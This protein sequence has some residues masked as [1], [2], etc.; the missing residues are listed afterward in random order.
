MDKS[1]ENKNTNKDEYYFG[2][3]SPADAEA[4][5]FV[6]IGDTVYEATR[7]GVRP[8][9]LT[10]VKFEKDRIRFVCEAVPEQD[11]T[12][13]FGDELCEKVFFAKKEKAEA[14]VTEL[15]KGKGVRKREIQ[16]GDIIYWA[17][18]KGVET[19]QVVRVF[20][21]EKFTAYEIKDLDAPC[22]NHRIFSVL[23]GDSFV[24]SIFF[25]RNEAEAR[26][27]ELKETQA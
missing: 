5:P 18:P 21:E 7:Q 13:C 8:L 12:V 24:H 23:K 6:K 16:L 15:N 3:L 25:S 22:S 11:F 4:K 19:Y 2:A 10:N 1:F 26:V 9:R 17:K 20:Y 14:K 27:K